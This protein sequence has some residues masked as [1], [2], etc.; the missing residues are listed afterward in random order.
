MSPLLFNR[1]LEVIVTAIRERKEIKWN[2]IRKEVKLSLCADDMRLYT[3]NSKDATRKLLELIHKFGKVARCIINTDK[4]VTFL[5]T[6]NKRSEREIKEITPF[7][8]TSKKIYIYLGI[9]IPNS[10]IYMD[11][12]KSFV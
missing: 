12:Q 6:N 8:M 10:Q 4:S 3:E 7:T 9:N 1:V 11:T 5:Y 2:Q